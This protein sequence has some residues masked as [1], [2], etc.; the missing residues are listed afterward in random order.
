MEPEK[1]WTEKDGKTKEQNQGECFY[2]FYLEQV[3]YFQNPQC[4][5]NTLIMKQNYLSSL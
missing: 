4:K 3:I 5:H 2:F 1:E